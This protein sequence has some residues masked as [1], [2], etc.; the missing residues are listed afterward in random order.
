M[1]SL[2]EVKVLEEVGEAASHEPYLERPE[3]NVSRET[4]GFYTFWGKNQRQ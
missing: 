3:R 1:I 2:F 4:D